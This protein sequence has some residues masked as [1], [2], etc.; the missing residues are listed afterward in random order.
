MG[1]VGRGI[2]KGLSYRYLLH[3]VL[4]MG[5]WSIFRI[6]LLLKQSYLIFISGNE[7]LREPCF[8]PKGMNSLGDSEAVATSA[9]DTTFVFL[10]RIDGH[11]TIV[12]TKMTSLDHLLTR[13]FFS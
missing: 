11:M 4:S 1:D 2:K 7:N 8:H 5:M 13:A 3:F 12:Q 9:T 10:H 6:S